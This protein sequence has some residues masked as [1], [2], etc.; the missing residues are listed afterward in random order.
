MGLSFLP[1]AD[2]LFHSQAELRESH[3]TTLTGHP[4]NVSSPSACQHIVPFPLR[5]MK[6]LR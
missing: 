2:A 1:L 3:G 4:L 6:K 5:L